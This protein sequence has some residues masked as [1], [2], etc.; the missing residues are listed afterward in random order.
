[1]ETLGSLWPNTKSLLIKQTSY[2]DLAQSKSKSPTLNKKK[3]KRKRSPLA[4]FGRRGLQKFVS[5]CKKK[6][7]KKKKNFSKSLCPILMFLREDFHSFFLPVQLSLVK[8]WLIRPL[9]LCVVCVC[10]CLCVCKSSEVCRGERH[11]RQWGSEQLGGYE[12]VCCDLIPPLASAHRHTHTHTHTH[13]HRHAHTHSLSLSLSLSLSRFPIQ[14]SS[15]DG[16][17]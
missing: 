1:M 5:T 15:C 3:K 2:C 6:T 4:L 12:C 14:V 10:V 16:E 17:G 7:K 13:T 9:K 11:E 8:Y